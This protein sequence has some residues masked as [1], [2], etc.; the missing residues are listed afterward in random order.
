MNVSVRILA[1]CSGIPHKDKRELDILASNKYTLLI[2]YYMAVALRQMLTDRKVYTCG[3]V[4][5]R[6][7]A[8]DN[9]DVGD[10]DDTVLT[11]LLELF[12][13]STTD[14]VKVFKSNIGAVP[15][16]DFDKNR[17]DRTE[18]VPANVEA[19]QPDMRNDD[20]LGG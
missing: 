3:D 6:F 18:P 4:D 17:I 2:S 9:D 8:N 7:K 15:K 1:A 13:P 19:V 10:V 20:S 16:V 5:I 12:H 11:E 14:M